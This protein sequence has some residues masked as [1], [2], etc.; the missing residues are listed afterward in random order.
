MKKINWQGIDGKTVVAAVVAAVV[1]VNS[2]LTMFGA[3]PIPYDESTIYAFFGALATVAGI[4]YAA[5]H[6]FNIT[7]AAQEGQKVTD[8][9]KRKGGK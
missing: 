5:W 3:N 7:K 4:A 6:N 1:A 8:G 9:L 2:V